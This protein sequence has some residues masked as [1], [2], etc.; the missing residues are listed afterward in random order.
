MLVRIGAE[1]ESGRV[2]CEAMNLRIRL[3]W[4]WILKWYR[5]AERRDCRVYDDDINV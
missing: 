2:V 1:L 5:S 3:E 4:S